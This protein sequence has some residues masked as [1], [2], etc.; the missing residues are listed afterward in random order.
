MFDMHFQFEKACP[1]LAYQ[2]PLARHVLA[3][4]LDRK[5]PEKSELSQLAAAQHRL[6]SVDPVHV[7]DSRLLVLLQ[8]HVVL[9]SKF[10]DVAAALAAGR[11][12]YVLTRRPG[13]GWLFFLNIIIDAAIFPDPYIQQHQLSRHALTDAHN[14]PRR[15]IQYW[16]APQPPADV[17]AMIDTWLRIP[18]Y[19][20]KLVNHAQAREFIATYYGERITDAYDA[21]GHV[22]SKA[23]IFR[24][25]WLHLYGGIYADADEK[26]VGNLGSVIPPQCRILLTWAQ[27][28]PPCIQNGF[29][30]VQPENPLIESALVLAVKRIEHEKQTGVRQTAWIQTGPGVVSMAV[31][32]DFALHGKPVAA[33]G[34]HLMRDPVHRKVV[35]SDE[36]LEY[37]RH[38]QGNWRLRG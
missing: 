21:A 11:C 29:I 25:A 18:G 6:L 37:R 13:H 36:F 24:L 14:I 26:L 23:D 19:E 5:L 4:L 16:D 15:I 17:A 20:H 12:L 1:I 30:A 7:I 38:P 22:A 27:G 2:R 28:T 31:L 33:M 34:L 8:E 10:G 35:Q 32:D 9:A 3:E